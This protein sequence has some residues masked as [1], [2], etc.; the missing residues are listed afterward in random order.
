MLYDAIIVGGNFAG[1]AA[2]LQLARVRRKVLVV[3]AGEPRN[4][5]AAESHGFLGQD[6]VAPFEIKRQGEHQ[7]LS[8]PDAAV[9]RDRVTRAEKT[10]G[11]FA[12]TLENGSMA[13]ARRLLFATGVRDVLPAVKGLA[14]RWGTS[15]LH[16]PYCHGYEVR[17]R[18]LGALAN[19]PWSA[20]TALLLPDLG[21]TTFF[22]QGLFEI[23]PQQERLLTGRSIIIE[24]TPIA[25]ILGKDKSVEAVRLDDGRIIDL[26]AIF[27]TTRTVVTNDVPAQLGCRLQELPFGVSLEVNEFQETS[28]Q[29]VFAAGDTASMMQSA[30]FAAAS[31][32][33]AAVFIHK[34]LAVEDA[35][36]GVQANLG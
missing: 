3:D 11:V 34:S 5:F 10:A 17:D 29:G 15:V 16:C 35:S 20:D 27:T 24:R 12:V 28:V 2:A 31:G 19:M 21:P 25:E 36:V 6:G 26:D 14:E 18:R 22:T 7:L 33:R 30:T 4:R 9:W 1:L 32:V 23:D 13:K 8:Y